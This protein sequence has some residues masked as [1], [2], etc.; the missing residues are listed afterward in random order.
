MA[1][2]AGVFNLERTGGSGLKALGRFV[3][4]TPCYES[5]WADDAVMIKQLTEL[6]EIAS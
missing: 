2:M 4:H 1:R 5:G 6:S 3:E